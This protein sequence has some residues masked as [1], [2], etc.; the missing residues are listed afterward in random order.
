[1]FDPDKIVQYAP[2]GQHIG[3][4]CVNHPDMRWH[5]KN[6]GCIGMRT[7][8]FSDF[9]R[10]CDCPAS[11]LRPLP[12]NGIPF[13][14]DPEFRAWYKSQQPLADTATYGPGPDSEPV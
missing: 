3:L 1:M 12:E 14:S 2:Y 8:F 9:G 13:A 4:Y 5:T 11:C 10:E 6:I 7:I